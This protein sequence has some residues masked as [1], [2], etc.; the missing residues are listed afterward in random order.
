M[1]VCVHRVHIQAAHRVLFR[2]VEMISFFLFIFKNK[3]G[4]LNTV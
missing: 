2:A 3:A 1:S 4:T